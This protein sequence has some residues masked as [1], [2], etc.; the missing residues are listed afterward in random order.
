MKLPSYPS[1]VPLALLATL[2]VATSSSSRAAWKDYEDAGVILGRSTVPSPSTLYTPQDIAIN[3]ASGKAY[4]VDGSNNR[5]LRFGSAAALGNG[6]AAEAVFGQPDLTSTEPGLTQSSLDAPQSAAVDAAGRLWISDTEN[7]RILRWD[8]ADTAANGALAAQVL[9]QP[10][11]TSRGG[12]TNQTGLS[13]PGGIAIDPLGRLWVVDY[14]SNRVL[15]YDNPSSKGNGGAADG[16]IGQ[17]DFTSN[18]SGTSATQLDFPYDVEAD[19]TGRIWVSEFVSARILRFD[20]PASQLQPAA[21]GVLGQV[22]FTGSSAGSGPAKMDHP[23]TLA[24]SSAGSLF[25][26]DTG[27]TRILRWDNAAAKTNGADADGVLGRGGLGSNDSYADLNAAVSNGTRGMT[28][29]SSGRL[30]AV[31]RDLERVMHWNNAAAKANGAPAD[32]I[33]GQA[34]TSATVS[35]SFN[36]ETM[37]F[38]VR[39]GLEDPVSGKFFLAD[40]GRGSRC[41]A[42]SL[43]RKGQPSRLRWRLALGRDPAQHL[44][45]GDGFRGQALGQ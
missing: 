31:D 33:I 1:Q 9:G 20:N 42:G 11:F 15:R 24:V 18:G 13:R 32:G 35:S 40:L 36:P 38:W 2:I 44:E 39:H 10:D 43:A 16:V 17:P 19:S 14:F 25:V 30:W 45:P 41:P 22:D 7:Q 37:P 6:Q 23:I 5:V 28:V 12:N 4:V 8:N 27:N 34:N 26:M 29:D 3:P 21:N